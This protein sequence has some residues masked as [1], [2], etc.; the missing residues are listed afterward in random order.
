MEEKG[1]L[2]PEV[3]LRLHFLGMFSSCRMLKLWR[4]A[5]IS[6]FTFAAIA[7]PLPSPWLMV[8]QVALL[9]LLYLSIGFVA[10]IHEKWSAWKGD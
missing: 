1:F 5:V 10:Y 3:L 7:N 4:W 2:A 8:V 9:I 6:F